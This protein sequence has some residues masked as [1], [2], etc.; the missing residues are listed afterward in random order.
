MRRERMGDLQALVTG[1][2][3]GAL[4]RAPEFG[5]TIEVEQVTDEHGYLPELRVRGLQTDERLVVR[6]EKDE[7]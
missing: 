7:S 1:A 4:M 2:L 6:I 5:L 3:L